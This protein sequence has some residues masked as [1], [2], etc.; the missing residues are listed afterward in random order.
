MDNQFSETTYAPVYISPY[1]NWSSPVTGIS[2]LESYSLYTGQPGDWYRR[3]ANVGV[4]LAMIVV[5]R[6]IATAWMWRFHRGKN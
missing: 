2:V 6:A 4:L 5:Y 3:W 1:E